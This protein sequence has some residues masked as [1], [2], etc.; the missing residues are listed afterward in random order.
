[1]DYEKTRLGLQQAL[2]PQQM[3]QLADERH[4]QL[5]GVSGWCRP[6]A[7]PFHRQSSC[8]CHDW[9]QLMQW[10]AGYVLQGLLPVHIEEAFFSLLDVL[11]RL[12]ETTADVEAGEEYSDDTSLEALKLD[13]VKAL[14]AL[15]DCVPMTEAPIVI[16]IIM[17]V[18]DA[19]CR[20]NSVNN[21]WAFF[22]ER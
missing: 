4:R 15:E 5:S 8:K 17:H 22:T 12:V 6:S 2:V 10:S 14:I 19:I 9:K 3:Q 16:H 1:M 7:T 20:W 21:F 11:N 13:I 18:P